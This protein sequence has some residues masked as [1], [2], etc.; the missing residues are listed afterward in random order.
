MRIFKKSKT[1]PL[2]MWGRCMYSCI[3][4]NTQSFEYKKVT[5]CQKVS[6]KVTQN[7]HFL[8][9]SQSTDYKK[10]TKGINLYKFINA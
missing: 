9:H 3:R 5:L 4:L 7:S 10:I 2:G 1:F 8:T 6:I